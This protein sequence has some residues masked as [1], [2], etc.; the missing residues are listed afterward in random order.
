M[1]ATRSKIVRTMCPMNC[2]PTYCGMLAELEGNNLKVVRGDK[3]NPDMLKP[4]QLA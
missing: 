1:S 3:E 4:K 2:H